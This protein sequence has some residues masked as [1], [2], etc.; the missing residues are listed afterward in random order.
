MDDAIDSLSAREAERLKERL[1]RR[2]QRCIICDSDGA[3]P[4]RVTIHRPSAAFTLLMC[5][6][7]IEKHRLPES[8]EERE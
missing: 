8:R 7:C 1:E 5:P 3:I 2:L 4:V 6:A